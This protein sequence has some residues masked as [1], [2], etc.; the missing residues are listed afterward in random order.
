MVG[1]LESVVID[2]PDPRSLA[3][4]YVELL[5][6]KV[7]NDTENNRWVVISD[8]R[9]KIAFQ[10][11]PDLRAPEWPDPERP[12]QFHLDVLV[13]DIDAAEA[14]ALA[15]GAKRLPGEGDGFRVYADPVGHPF[16]LV[17][18]PA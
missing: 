1:H 7:R 9:R 5:Q 11:A 14:T 4:F 8:E 3:A 10:Q 13:D 17:T 18:G 12:Q 2:C 6:M 15:L 16:C